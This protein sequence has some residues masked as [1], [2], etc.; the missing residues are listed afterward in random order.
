[1]N[2]IETILQEH[3]LNTEQSILMGQ[4]EFDK[5]NI[6]NALKTIAIV[7]PHFSLHDESHSVSILNNIVKMLGV[8][9]IKK[10]SCTDLWL[11]LESAYSHD[12]GMVV[13][14]ERLDETLKG[15]DIL[16]HYLKIAADENH[17]CYEYTK[18]FVKKDGKLYMREQELKTAK[19]DSV[20]FFLADYFRSKHAENSKKT[21]IYSLYAQAGRFVGY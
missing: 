11:L 7:F 19:L 9:N 13:T 2:I 12:L 8:D 21:K 14:A 3:S 16:K 17:P 20:R 4:W 15:E 18:C 10:L 6:P 5:K 1:M